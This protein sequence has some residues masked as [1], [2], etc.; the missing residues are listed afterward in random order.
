MIGYPPALDPGPAYHELH[1][2]GA[3][4]KISRKAQ[5][6]DEVRRSDQESKHAQN[7]ESPAR[8]KNQD[9]RSQEG[10]EYYP[11]QDIRLADL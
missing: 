8:D 6:Q 7:I 3:E 4:D 5:T 2:V 10:Q 9:K 1:L 11:A